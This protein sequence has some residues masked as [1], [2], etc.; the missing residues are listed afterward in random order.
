[1]TR[2]AI[3]GGGPG[4]YEAAL[5]AA[6]L[7]AE[8]TIVDRDGIG[9]AAVLTDCVPSKTLIATADVMT[10]FEAAPELGVRVGDGG[11]CVTGVDLARVNARVLALAAKQSE[12][13][14]EGLVKAGV[15]VLR[16]S[17]RLV[18]GGRAVEA[19]LPE[20]G[21]LTIQADAVILATGARPRELADRKS[22]V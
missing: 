9:G 15:T 5:V 6:R 2:I 10:A 7:G 11:R 1:M 18:D 14:A 3:I 21:R 4:G 12:D 13:I 8:V 19:A 16:G 22:V 20:G 17:G